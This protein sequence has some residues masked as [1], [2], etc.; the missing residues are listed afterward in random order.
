MGK[1]SSS[2][3]NRRVVNSMLMAAASSPL[4]QRQEVHADT[5][6]FAIKPF[7]V[8][9]PQARID[10]ILARVR[11]AEW[12][13]RLDAPDTRYGVNWDYMRALARYWTG[14]FDWRKAESNLNR[15]PQFLA[16]VGD[17]VLIEETRPLSK[18]KRWR[19]KEVL[20]RAAIVPE[21]EGKTQKAS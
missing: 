18:L 21:T 17:Y 10:H 13:D 1:T 20:R 9:I 12:P 6:A 15:F 5:A 4:L 8:D 2:K 16:R 3:P 7:R 14:V 19:L 11:E